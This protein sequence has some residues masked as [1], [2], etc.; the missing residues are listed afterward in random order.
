MHWGRV[1]IHARITHVDTTH[2]DA[3]PR[4]AL[5][6]DAK[7]RALIAAGAPPDVVFVDTHLQPPRRTRPVATCCVLAC[8]NAMH[9]WR[10]CCWGASN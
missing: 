2:A 6:A 4:Y 8:W 10:C 7:A 3:P 1:L 9:P 5:L